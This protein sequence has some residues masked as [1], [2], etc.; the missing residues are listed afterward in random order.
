MKYRIRRTYDEF[1]IR[2]LH[3]ETFPNDEYYEHIGNVYW[4]VFDENNNPVGFCIG[5]D[6]GDNIFF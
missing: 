4:L 2:Q 3:S 1:I 5:T 6:I